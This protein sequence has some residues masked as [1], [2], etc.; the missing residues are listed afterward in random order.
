LAVALGRLKIVRSAG[1]MLGLLGASYCL[2]NGFIFFSSHPA[3]HHD[4]DA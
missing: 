3:K 2:L 1:A 4:H